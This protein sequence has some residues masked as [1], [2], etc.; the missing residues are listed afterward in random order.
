MEYTYIRK[1]PVPTD[2]EGARPATPNSSGEVQAS[3]GSTDTGF[4]LWFAQ[5]SIV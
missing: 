4:S 5:G 2:R 3:G 1:P